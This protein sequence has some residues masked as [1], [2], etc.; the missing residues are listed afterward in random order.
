MRP[1][2]TTRDPL[3]VFLTTDAVGGVW[4]HAAELAQG[5]AAHGAAVKLAVLG[6]PPAVAEV[7]GCEV[8][9]TGLPL[10]WAGA[11]AAA[12]RAAGRA[13]VTM[14]ADAEVVH[15]NSPALAAGGDFAGPLVA[16][17][18]SCVATWWEAVRGGPLPVELAWQR[19]L[20]AAGYGAAGLLVAPSAAFAAQ[21]ARSY[22]LR[23]APRVVHNGAR[24]RLL[25]EPASRSGV[26]AAGRLWDEAKNIAL[27][28]RIAPR[29][30]VP[31]AVAGPL[32]APQGGRAAFANLRHLGTLDGRAMAERLAGAAVFVSPARYEPFGLAVLEA[33]QAGCALLLADL[34]SFREIWGETADY[35]PIDDEGAF[36]D[37]LRR[38]TG[39]AELRERR[40]S[41]ARR[42]A[43]RF[44]A[45][46][47]VEGMLRL[48]C[49]LL[50]GRVAME[51]AA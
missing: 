38:L 46:A 4:S 8:L 34:P 50:P 16:G 27:L 6:P 3:R 42:R 39:D 21:T 43:A 23:E 19:E 12:V 14:A 31:I 29:L 35:A 10:D 13:L 49:E 48:Y 2:L 51:A 11:D 9:L 41:E 7:P 44:G 24:P 5:L 26:L 33:A 25:V 47:M 28:D 17:C 22:R 32:E 15:L 20:V 37:A 40:G 1:P 45:E 36:L 18:H 30:G